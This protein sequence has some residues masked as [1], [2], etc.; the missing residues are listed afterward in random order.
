MEII[1]FRQ[2]HANSDKVT[3]TSV[4][5]IARAFQRRAACHDIATSRIMGL[6]LLS[7]GMEVV[8]NEI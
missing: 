8:N 7:F 6:F 3:C 1:L 4:R 5:E 2:S